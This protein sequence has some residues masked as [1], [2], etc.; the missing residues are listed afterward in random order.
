M[1]VLASLRELC[2]GLAFAFDRAACTSCNSPFV[3][4]VEVD[5]GEVVNTF[6][7]DCPPCGLQDRRGHTPIIDLGRDQAVTATD[8]DRRAARYWSRRRAVPVGRTA[9]IRRIRA[10]R[11][12]LAVT[13]AR[14]PR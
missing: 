8:L 12:V 1:S 7:G 3:R 4:W 14:R 10:R 11:R 9:E 6:C 5:G 13:Q 2:R